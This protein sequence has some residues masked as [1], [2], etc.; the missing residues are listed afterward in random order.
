MLKLKAK[1]LAENVHYEGFT[2]SSDWLEKIGKRYQIIFG[3]VCDEGT[4]LNNEDM[5]AL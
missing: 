1:E 3:A 5:V 2:A 4:S